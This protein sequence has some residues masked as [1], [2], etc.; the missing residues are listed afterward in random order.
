MS[1]TTI[2][3]RKFNPDRDARPWQGGSRPYDLIKEVTICFL[4][5]TG[6]VVGLAFL[7]GSPDDKAISIQTW[8][9]ADQ[10]DFAQTSISELNGTSGTATYGPP[11]NNFV[12]SSQ[13][14]GPI[15]LESWIGVHIPVNPAQDFVLGPLSTVANAPNVTRVLDVF[16]AATPSQQLAWETKYATAVSHAS[17]VNGHLVVPRGAYG[18]IGVMIGQL[19]AMAKSGALDSAMVDQSGFYGTNYTKSLLYIAD[20][21]YFAAQGT[22][23]HLSGDQW[24]MMNETGNFPGQAW[25]W[26]Y[27]FWYQVPPFSSSANADIQVSALMGLLSLLLLLVPFIPGLRS[28]PRWTRVYRFIWKDYYRSQG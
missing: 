12:G 21:T 22:A 8:A 13:S 7:F 17:S 18:P 19:T 16:N 28:L 23:H 20:S 11:Y 27:T 1:E 25:L 15:S 6:L 4:V 3:Q 10:I 5:V 2:L 24:G 26:L 9:T 14:L